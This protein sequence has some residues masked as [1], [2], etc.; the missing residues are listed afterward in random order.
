MKR[1]RLVGMPFLRC[2][3][4]R[5][6]LCHLRPFLCR[7]VT[8]PNY[9][10]LLIRF[11]DVTAQVPPANRALVI[12]FAVVVV[13]VGVFFV[14][15]APLYVVTMHPMAVML[16]AGHPKPFVTRV[17][18]ARTIVIGSVAD[19][20]RNSYL[21]RARLYPRARGDHRAGQRYQ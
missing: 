3:T 12:V 8:D 7:E 4:E 6:D 20:D 13:L 9:A 17:P 19:A 18:I 15:F 16:V 1:T 10:A 5:Y 11:L 14:E 21:A 2:R